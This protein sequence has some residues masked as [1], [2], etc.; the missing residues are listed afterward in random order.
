MRIK[1][2]AGALLASAQRW[3]HSTPESS[4]ITSM[5]AVTIDFRI[6]L[7]SMSKFTFG[8]TLEP[9]LDFTL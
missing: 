7:H 8:G 2:D 3:D 6:C 9:V 4:S 5:W 1:S